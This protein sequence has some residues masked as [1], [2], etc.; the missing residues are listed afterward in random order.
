M[1]TIYILYSIDNNGTTK[2]I[3]RFGSKHRLRNAA[4]GLGL[5]NWFYETEEKVDTYDGINLT[6]LVKY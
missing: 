2:F 4:I 1:I 3:G 6:Q 5:S